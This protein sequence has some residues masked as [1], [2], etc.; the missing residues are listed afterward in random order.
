MI[1]KRCA[2]LLALALL[3][4]GPA[5]AVES[6]AAGSAP[7]DIDPVRALR[8]LQR[9]HDAL[10]AQQ[11]ALQESAAQATALAE[12]NQQLDQQLQNLQA[13]L[14][15]LREET[16]RLR[17]DDR[18]RWFI[19]GAAVLAAGMLLGLLLPLLRRRRRGYG[20]FR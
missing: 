1:R 16:S 10:V 9:E 5:V 18:R 12:Q 8:T 7:A 6:V 17:S 15:G 11:P 13:Q 20:G 4:S 3:P 19:T 2:F 14:D